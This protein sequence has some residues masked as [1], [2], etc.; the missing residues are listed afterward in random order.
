MDIRNNYINKYDLQ[1][2]LRFSLIPQGKTL[3]NIEKFGV[4]NVDEK[5][6][7]KYKVV[8]KLI[9]SKHKAFIEKCLH[10]L[11]LGDELLIYYNLYRNKSKSDD[12]ANEMKRYE[13]ILRK[14]IAKAFTSDSDY[15]S[16]F[17]KDLF[18]EALYNLAETD[19][20]K[21]AFE[22]FC[23][24]FT[25][26]FSNFNTNRENMYSSEEKSTSISFRLI[27]QN[28]PKFIDNIIA[29]EEIANSSLTGKFEALKAEFSGLGVFEV[30]DL[31][32][33][34]YFNFVLSQSGITLYN[35]FIGGYTT[36]DGVK[37]Q[38]LNEY[39]N[40]YNQEHKDKQKLP[41]MKPLFKQILSD[42]EHISFVADKFESDNEL[43]K[44]IDFCYGEEMF[45]TINEIYDIFTDL[46]HFD[47]S[48]VYIKNGPAVTELSNG[49]FE[50]WSAI[51]DKL[52]EV[53]DNEYNGKAKK[54]SEKYNDIRKKH[55]KNIPSYSLAYL[56][57]IMSDDN[58]IS[59][60]YSDEIN[61]RIKVLNENYE[62]AKALIKSEYQ[63]DQHIASDEEACKIIKRL[64]DSTIELKNFIKPLLG[65]QKEAEKDNIFYGRFEPAYE[66][67]DNITLLYNKV[68]NYL[69]QKPYSIEKIKLN[70]E[71][72]VFLGGWAVNNET[73]Y[74]SILL[75]KDKKYYL[76]IMEQKS[77]SSF[78]NYPQPTNNENCFKKMIYLQ[79]ADPQKDVQNLMVID[80]KTVK[81]NGRK[82]KETGEN[83]ILE[84]LKNTYLPKDINEIRKNKSYSKTSENFSKES[85]IKFID[86]YKQR[87]IEYFSDYDFVFKSSEEYSDFGQFT[88][89]INQQAYQIHFKDIPESYVY[90]LVNEGKLY[91]FQIYNKDFSEH[92]KGTENLH[93]MYFKMLFDE[94][95]LM[96]VVYKLNGGAEMFYRKAS[97]K[98]KDIVVHHKN[99]PIDNKNTQNEKKQSEFSY[100]IIKDRR[101][102][103][104]KF[105]LHI[106]I[107]LNFKSQGQNFINDDVRRDIKSSDD[108]C[109]IGI[110][111][112]E[113]NL[114]YISV[115]SPD[116]KIIE[117]HSLNEIIN[118]HNNN[119]YKIDYHKLLDDKEVDR[120]EARKEWKT[121]ENI[122]ELKEGY[123][124]QV[125]HKIV[126]LM[127][128]YNAI[129][130]MEDLNNGM[131]NSRIKV[132]KQVYQKFENM[133]T[134]KLKYCVDKQKANEDIEGG[135]LKAYQLVNKDFGGKQNGFI[136]YIPA[137]NTSKI[138]PVT[139]FA[140]LFNLKRKSIDESKAF[141]NTFDS[142]TYNS[143]K[144]YF[145]FK[146]DY[147]NF[148]GRAM[149]DYRRNWTV[150]TY[151][152]RIENFRNA[153][154]NSMWDSRLVNVT[155]EF[156]NLYNQYGIDYKNG[157]FKETMVMQKEK[158]FFTEFLRLFK[159]TVQM[160]NSVLKSTKPED[161]YMISPVC[162]EKGNFYDSR[163]FIG[164]KNAELP[165]DADA[166]G[167]Y[168]IARKGLWAI[169]QIKK[170]ET[171][172]EL[173]KARISITNKEWLEFAQK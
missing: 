151:G 173:K 5:R 65:S 134:E 127:I 26:Y 94:K 97:I 87:V 20:E 11:S 147:H 142:I 162:D 93:T 9:D 133:L 148:G 138:D 57:E 166:N 46:K 75:M 27:N 51:S 171:E 132:E 158:S 8:K 99:E 95:N 92:S 124:S 10:H 104:D 160:R 113:R 85:L 48:K 123:L 49:V 83:L 78:R 80:G 106:P 59:E 32:S 24:G 96:N 29:F 79:A 15:K 60:Y 40:L 135:L 116:G 62:S 122:K 68:R 52:N 101:F 145:E 18:D 30:E 74:S 129:V 156:K 47:L 84:N 6:A 56:S 136:F 89:D 120:L 38:G 146:F 128:K 81:K 143:E 31:F 4:L 73:N 103:V 98:E 22:L 163:N 25:T 19:E 88:N 70:F 114:I 126:Q 76:G 14:K 54:D 172:Q 161:D 50:S 109:V 130:V 90:S 61:I 125:V 111:R 1:K 100:D 35:N 144:D 12:E 118:T 155:E 108:V 44:A 82:D 107:T 102:T 77:K 157:D 117:Q 139:G 41:L 28:L 53:F 165:V 169:S 67:L 69:T 131:K 13:E 121:I 64:L 43:L 164:V 58:K 17:G 45:L 152:D 3:E 149:S 112:G 86:F 66:M 36:S 7:E 110:D 23:N 150:C 154:N 16:L 170:A 91:L 39:I 33:I 37:I 141:I 105:Q 21:E 137:W 42:R 2:T 55:F 71:N 159:L 153:D 119:V 34:D 72:S 140:C 168:N 115:V 63:N 167:A